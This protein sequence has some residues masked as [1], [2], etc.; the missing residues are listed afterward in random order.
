[1]APPIFG[2]TVVRTLDGVAGQEIRGCLGICGPNVQ[3]L[4]GTADLATSA[5]NRSLPW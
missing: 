4:C 1:M 5:L 3:C 2:K